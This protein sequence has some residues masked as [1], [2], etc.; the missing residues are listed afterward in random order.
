MTLEEMLKAQGLTDE[1]ISKITSGMKENKIYI[2]SEENI[3]ERYQK[4]KEQKA[5]L[6]TQVSTAT[7]TIADL[8]KGNKDN[9]ELQGK[10]TQYETDLA[11][12][13]ADSESKIK[14]I[15]IDNAIKLALKDNKA[16]HEDLLIGK[17]DR[18]KL[19]LKEDGK[20]EGLEDQIKGFKESYKELFEQPLGGT[21]PNNKGNSDTDP[22]D[23]FL[24]GFNSEI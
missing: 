14:N 18:E 2:T 12:L 22:K 23:P 9:E 15:T 10:I 5:D 8:K 19:V 3:E 1:Q 20:I 21:T 17:F 4:L 13:K 16:K 11:T 7:T 6:E 24:Q